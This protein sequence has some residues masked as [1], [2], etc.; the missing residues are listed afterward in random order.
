VGRIWPSSG[1]NGVHFAYWRGGLICGLLTAPAT[2]TTEARTYISNTHTHSK[3]RRA[4]AA[5]LLFG[6]SQSSKVVNRQEEVEVRHAPHREAAY[7]YHIP[8]GALVR[9]AWQ[10]PGV[11]GREGRGRER[12]VTMLCWAFAQGLILLPRS[13]LLWTRNPQSTEAMYMA[14]LGSGPGL[15][16]GNRLSYLLYIYIYRLRSFC[17]CPSSCSV[18]RSAR[19]DT[20]THREARR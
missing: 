4:A 7:R 14:P 5:T 11:G 3:R 13:H 18:H 12:A 9:G 20:T 17:L 16:R 15:T 6:Y 19:P 2:S 10:G 1:Y 8:S